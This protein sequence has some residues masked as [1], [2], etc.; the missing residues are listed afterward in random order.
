MYASRSSSSPVQTV[1][2]LEY[3]GCADLA[4]FIPNS[5][6]G[7]K[8]QALQTVLQC[9]LHGDPQQVTLLS[10]VLSAEA[11]QAVMPDQTVSLTQHQ[12][13]QAFPFLRALQALYQEHKDGDAPVIV[14]LAGIRQSDDLDDALT[15]SMNLNLKA[16]QGMTALTDALH[17]IR[18]GF[19]RFDTVRLQ[20]LL[21][22]LPMDSVPVDKFQLLTLFHQMQLLKQ[23]Q[24]NHKM[25]FTF[26]ASSQQLADDVSQYFRDACY[27][28]DESVTKIRKI[29]CDQGPDRGKLAAKGAMRIL[30]ENVAL[31]CLSSGRQSVLHEAAF[32]QMPEVVAD[33][34]DY[35]LP[36]NGFL[37]DSL[38]LHSWFH[39]VVKDTRI[40]ALEQQPKSA[41]S[42]DAAHAVPVASF[43]DY[44]SALTVAL[45][46]VVSPVAYLYEDLGLVDRI[47]QRLSARQSISSTFTKRD[48]RLDKLRHDLC[49]LTD[50]V[51]SA[52]YA[53]VPGQS[54]HPLASSRLTSQ[55]LDDSRMQAMLA[56]SELHDFL[57]QLF[58]ATHQGDLAYV[59]SGSPLSLADAQSQ[60]DQLSQQL[61]TSLK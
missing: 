9:A 52:G 25:A 36:G 48:S 26:C 61:Y 28:P 37:L 5:A 35:G 22:H 27:Y 29:A 50:T 60:V 49:A 59:P 14:T 19:C 17:H 54:L 18:P 46:H 40:T 44:V 53:W 41:P 51:H 24:P 34:P 8:V 6:D 43:L 21:Q 39:D 10:Q 31:R 1:L 11:T 38:A 16:M 32:A 7:D 42:S 2:A 58:R 20:D 56:R 57:A 12:L 30:P 23:Q 47:Y 4:A 33:L 15:K 3:D 13:I 45:N 55:S